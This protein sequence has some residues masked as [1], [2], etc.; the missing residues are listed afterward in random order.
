MSWWLVNIGQLSKTMIFLKMLVSHIHFSFFRKIFDFQRKGRWCKIYAHMSHTGV[1]CKFPPNSHHL[2]QD[3]AMNQFCSMTWMSESM[4]LTCLMSTLSCLILQPS[5]ICCAMEFYTTMVEF[6]W[7]RIFW[8]KS[9]LSTNGTWVEVCIWSI[10]T[11]HGSHTWHVFQLVTSCPWSHFSKKS[12]VNRQTWMRLSHDDVPCR[13]R[14]WKIWTTSFSWR[15]RKSWCRF[16][17]KILH[18]KNAPWKSKQMH[19]QPNS[20]RME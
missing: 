10:S 14:P 3:F 11:N 12:G 20:E 1:L 16:W 5:Q 8:P 6:T 7:M 9:Q 18:T 4:S 17:I 15:R 19:Q 13:T 2:A